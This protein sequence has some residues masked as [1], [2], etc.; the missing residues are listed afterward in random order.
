MGFRNRKIL[1]LFLA[2]AMIFGIMFGVGPTTASAEEAVSKI[3]IVH[4]NDIHGRVEKDTRDGSIGFPR[5]KTKLDE[6]RAED[7][8][9]LLLNAGDTLHG[10]V[11]V[12]VTKGA[13]MVGLMNT[14]GFDAMVP[15]NHDFNHGY[16]RLLELRDLA[17]FPMVGANIMKEDET[18]DFVPYTI[19]EKIPGVKIGI[20]GLGTDETKFKSHPDNTKGIEFADPIETAKR[21][22]KELKEKEVD[23]II[24]L[25]H[26]GNE[27]TTTVTS[28]EV[29]EAVEGIDLIVDGHSHEKLNE[30]VGDALLV[31][32]GEYVKNI[33]I[34][35]LEIE[36]G[37]ISKKTASLFT[38]E[39]AQELEEDAEMLKE[40]EKINTE[41]EPILSVVVGKTA[42]DLEGAR[43]FVRIGETN[44]GN[45]IADAMVE[46]TGAD[47]GFTNGGGIRASIPAG[48]I[49]VGDIMTSFPFNNFLS[50]IE[51]TGSEVMEALEKGVDSYPE[52]A[53]HYPHVSGMKYKFDPSKEV[54]SRIVEVIVN[55]EPIDLEKTYKLVTNDFIAIGGDGYTMF[56]GKPIIAEGA[57]LSDA[58]IEHVK[59]L[60]E[61]N[62]VVEG[63]S[64]A[65]SVEAEKY[66]V[67]A[68]DVLWK[69]AKKFNTT[70][71]KLAEFNELKN[72]HLIFPNQVILVP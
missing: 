62:P 19:I 72:P 4:L 57:L 67:Q 20:F 35:E 27:G 56:I 2:F 26:L 68:G 8:N 21:I 22:V 47:I 3:T 60:G 38:Y 37:K 18:S 50:V 34:V 71:E 17:D 45:L 30:E 13:T 51:I 29:G 39:Q 55:N 44:L 61:L 14:L 6:L 23:I 40:I 70:W 28:R 54:G 1:S 36:N 65:I 48:D 41:N 16:E 53:G 25:V 12:N 9:L 43:E 7:P 52:Q 15:G 63:R 46:A 58:L 5:L 64:A 33:G 49:T 11:L 66:L 24:A 42:V 59:A 32:A 10:T 69:I 31:Q